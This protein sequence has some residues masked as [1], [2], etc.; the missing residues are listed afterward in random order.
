MKTID[1]IRM[2]LDRGL[3]DYVYLM[4]PTERLEYARSVQEEAGLWLMSETVEPG[5]FLWCCSRLRLDADFIRS[6]AVFKREE[7]DNHALPKRKK[8]K[9]KK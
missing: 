1:R 6:S 9:R 5:S 4:T 7:V 2:I 8:E 3:T